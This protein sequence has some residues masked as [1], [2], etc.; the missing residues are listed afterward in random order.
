MEKSNLSGVFYGIH[1][2]RA[3]KLEMPKTT[4]DSVLIKVEKAGICGTDLHIYHEA[5]V[6]PGSVLGHEFCGTITETGKNVTDFKVGERVVVNPMTQGVGLG[7]SPGGFAQY[8]KIDNVQKN[9]NLYSLPQNI[10]TTQGALIEPLAVGLAAVNKTDFSKDDITLVTG[11]GTIGLVT[12]AALKAKGVKNIIAS[13]ISEV[14]LEKAKSL[15]ATHTFNPTK[16]GDLKSFIIDIFGVRQALDY[17]GNLPNLN[18]AFECSGVSA[19]LSEVIDCLA[20]DGKLTVLAIYSKPITFDPNRIVYKRLNVQGTL[21][22]TFED[23]SEAIDL[24]ATGKIDVS[25]IVTHT[26]PLSEL[27]EA[28]KTQANSNIS[29]KVTVAMD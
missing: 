5:L 27:P 26:Y 22:Y 3:E 19:L 4:D 14:R 2:I 10:T 24:V 29:I 21:F 15:G 13:D 1:D 20:P 18:V 25:T 16:Q 17:S 6:P 28:F 12:I 11:C 8:I 9:I 23:F 7:V